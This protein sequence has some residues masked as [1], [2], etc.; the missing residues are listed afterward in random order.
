MLGGSY[1]NRSTK[2]K[3]G[4]RSTKKKK[5]KSFDKKKNEMELLHFYSAFVKMHRFYSVFDK[6]KKNEMEIVQ[7]FDREYKN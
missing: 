1:G 4:N 5:W 2:K 6:K 3:N 7:S